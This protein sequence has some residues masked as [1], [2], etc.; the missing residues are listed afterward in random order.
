MPDLAYD[1]GIKIFIDNNINSHIDKP[2]DILLWKFINRNYL[3]NKLIGN[4][5]TSADQHLSIEQI[6][7]LYNY[8]IIHKK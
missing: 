7:R 8:Y 6:Q 5:S 2:E 1:Y 3:P 4:F